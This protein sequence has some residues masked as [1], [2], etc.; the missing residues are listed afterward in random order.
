MHKVFWWGP[1]RDAFACTA[2]LNCW[3]PPWF[4]PQHVWAFHDVFPWPDPFALELFLEYCVPL[5]NETMSSQ[6]NMFRD[7]FND[8]IRARSLSITEETYQAAAV[9]LLNYLRSSLE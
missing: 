9:A 1:Q 6:F 4:G 8:P 5:E 3:P 2:L 7:F